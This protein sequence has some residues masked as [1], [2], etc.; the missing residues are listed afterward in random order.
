MID[1]PARTRGCQ[2][3]IARGTA[4]DA[5]HA[6]VGNGLRGPGA[7]PGRMEKEVAEAADVDVVRSA[8]PHRIKLGVDAR[9]LRQPRSVTGRMIDD[10]VNSVVTDSV[11]VARTAAPDRA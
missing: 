7:V 11:D 5:E 4:P 1:E 9:R 2:V 6:H 10:G 8:S 3:D